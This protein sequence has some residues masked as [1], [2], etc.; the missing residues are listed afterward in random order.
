VGTFVYIFFVKWSSFIVLV[1]AI[2]FSPLIR[3]RVFFMLQMFG[4]YNMFFSSSLTCF[5]NL[6]LGELFQLIMGQTGLLH[7]CSFIA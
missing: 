3:L 4:R 7:L 6:Y 2:S 5:A 1:M